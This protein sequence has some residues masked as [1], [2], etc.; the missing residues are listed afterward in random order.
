M[1]ASAQAR[2]MRPQ[3]FK[4]LPV[5]TYPAMA[6]VHVG[7][8]ARR[9]FFIQL[10]ITQ[11]ATAR[12]TPFQ[13]VMAEDFIFREAAIQRSFERLYVINTLADERPFLEHVL[14]DV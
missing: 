7:A 2:H 10:H 1:A 9:I 12:V 8:V 3:P 14:I 6:P 5:A 11:Q 13:Q 4:Q